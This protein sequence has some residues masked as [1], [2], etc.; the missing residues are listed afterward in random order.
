[1]ARIGSIAAVILV[2]LAAAMVAEG[3]ANTDCVSECYSE[4]LQ[5]KIFNEDFCNQECLISCA[6]FVIRETLQQKDD[7]T[8]F[9]SWI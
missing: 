8:F 9:P 2:A 5:I 4:C 3:S 1:M 7:S 6:R